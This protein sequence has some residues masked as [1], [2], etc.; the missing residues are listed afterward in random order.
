MAGGMPGGGLV[1]F[2]GPKCPSRLSNG[3]RQ[4]VAR[5]AVKGC[6]LK[7]KDK[8]T[9]HQRVEML[10]IRLQGTLY[11]YLEACHLLLLVLPLSEPVVL[12]PRGQCLDPD[13][14]T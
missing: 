1:D 5:D 11:I 2:W 4:R 10:M 9:T 7:M 8:T 3:L 12:F 13:R 6:Y 14:S